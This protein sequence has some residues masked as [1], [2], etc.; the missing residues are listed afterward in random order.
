MLSLP[1]LKEDGKQLNTI[2]NTSNERAS[3]GNRQIYDYFSVKI[4]RT[5]IEMLFNNEKDERYL[6]F[7]R[8]GFLRRYEGKGDILYVEIPQIPKNIVIYRKPTIRNKNS[9]K[10]Y[11]NKKDLP[12]IPLLEGE[13]NLKLLSLE[14][15]L[16][17][18]ID[19]LISLN[20]LLFLNL[21]ENKISEIENL[22]TV[23]KLKALMLG[24]NNI[25]KIKNLQ[26]LP[27]IEVLDLHS[28]K[29]KLIENLS[30]LKKL[31]ILNLANNQLTSFVELM[32]NKNLED[33]N[34]R[35]NLIVSI[36]NLALSFDKLRKLNLGKN[37]ISKIEF[38]LEFKKLKRIEE[39]YI[40]G[41]PVIFIKDAYKKFYNLPL[42]FKDQAQ[43]QIYKN[44][45]NGNN[46][47]NNNNN[48]LNNSV[49]QLKSNISSKSTNGATNDSNNIK[50][51]NSNSNFV[52]T[53]TS[54]IKGGKSTNFDEVKKSEN[55]NTN[56][57]N[58][59]NNQ[60]KTKTNQSAR[61]ESL[62]NS[63]LYYNNNNRNNGGNNNNTKN[64]QDNL[65]EEEREKLLVKIENEWKVEFRY[66]INNGFNGYS[67]K[68]LKETK[69]Q[70]CHAEIERERQLNLFGNAIEVLGY[71]EFYNIVHTIKFEF[72][73]FDIISQRQNIENIKKFMN[74]KSLVFKSNNMHGFYQ[75]IKLE[76]IKGI[77]YIT[78]KKNEICNGEILKYFLVYRLQNIKYFNDNE[79]TNKDVYMSKKIFE[80]FDQAISICE[81]ESQ[82][83]K[84]NK[85]DKENGS[86]LV[87]RKEIHRN[88]VEENELRYNFFSYA[89][90]N[91]TTALD[92]ILDL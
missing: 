91:L 52:S 19:H 79:I 54:N 72:I 12:H 7:L 9:E 78:I 46:Q 1:A 65:S 48:G 85:E 81:N 22:Q 33:I 11:L 73:N 68:K 87:N 89:K 38:I 58:N 3:S 15:N 45:T 26:C 41:N 8:Y 86:A 10:L 50:H 62:T 70:L 64:D 14:T 53:S 20:N 80:H 32:N 82:K 16:I 25:S 18:K 84:N 69:M 6:Y 66:I 59:D 27:E 88:E 60:P 77:E 37:M 75:I 13:E 31:R 34:L 43:F 35:K 57:N 92:E 23:P 56:N 74:L 49:S 76:N 36:P 90:I 47:N 61:N 5:T 44:N 67:I 63:N 24:K 4:S 17:T 42:K 2:K 55:S 40:E 29:I 30:S 51:A 71:K 39:L 83:A 28:N 21:Y